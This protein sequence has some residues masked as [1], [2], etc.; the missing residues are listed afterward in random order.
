MCIS[1]GQW[2]SSIFHCL[3]KNQWSIKFRPS[4]SRPGEEP[5][6]IKFWTISLISFQEQK[7]SCSSNTCIQTKLFLKSDSA[8][9]C[10]S[11]LGSRIFITMYTFPFS[12]RVAPWHLY[13]LKA[14]QV[15]LLDSQGCKPLRRSC[16]HI[17][18]PYFCGA[19]K[20]PL[21][22]KC[23]C[24]CFCKSSRW[25]WGHYK[26]GQNWRARWSCY[27]HDSADANSR[28]PSR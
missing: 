10:A 23:G 20:T 16:F 26:E 25:D 3:I 13:V 21:A 15:T 27:W 17:H 19:T 12:S 24:G 28:V 6:R 4:I 22:L 7:S 14:L 11:E 1:T 18:T 9:F 5:V 2:V 8:T